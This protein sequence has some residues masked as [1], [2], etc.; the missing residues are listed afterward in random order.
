[1]PLTR[2]INDAPSSIIVQ[3]VSTFGVWIVADR[4]G[5][6]GVLTIVGYAMT[7]ARTA[8]AR[9]PARLRVPSYAVWDTAVFV[10]NV[11]AFVLIGLQ[12]RPIWERLDERGRLKYCRRRRRARRRHPHA[13]RLGGVLRHRVRLLMARG[14]SRPM[15]RRRSGAI[16]VSWCGMRGIVTLAAALALPENFRT[17]T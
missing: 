11:L 3:F 17:A 16:V 7:L 8:P 4:I 15:L 1:M 14:I 2:R 5:L 13:H 6:S 10:L 12:M 9:T